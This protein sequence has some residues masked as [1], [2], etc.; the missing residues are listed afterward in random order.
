MNILW[1][2]IF[3]VLLL[4]CKVLLQIKETFD[5]PEYMKHKSRCFSCE[6]DIRQ[7]YGE[8]SIWMANPAKSF[9]AEIEAVNQADG[10]MSAGYLAKTIKYY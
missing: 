2:F 7:R 3:I 4:I 6:N 8:N 10:D 5:V 9:D 1:I